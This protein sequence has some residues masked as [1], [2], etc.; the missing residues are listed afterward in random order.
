MREALVLSPPSIRWKGFPE[1][2]ARQE[3]GLLHHGNSNEIPG[4]LVGPLRSSG[5][6]S[7]SSSADGPIH[8]VGQFGQKLLI[9]GAESPAPE[10][11]ALRA[12]NLDLDF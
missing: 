8:V 6:T 12:G 11:S 10:A 5:A 1:L 9:H 7:G 2:P 4:T 3:M